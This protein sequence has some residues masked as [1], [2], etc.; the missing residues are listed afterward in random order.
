MKEVLGKLYIL[1]L[2][3]IITKS[4]CEGLLRQEL[5][6]GDLDAVEFPVKQ[7]LL[8]IVKTRKR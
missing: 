7:P 8:S 4:A 3:I 2:G 5:C 1:G 6:R